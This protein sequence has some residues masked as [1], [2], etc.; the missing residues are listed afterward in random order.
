L[1]SGNII[2]S[3]GSYGL[4]NKALVPFDSSPLETKQEYLD[5]VLK[6]FKSQETDTLRLGE[7]IK[8]SRLTKTK[9][10]RSLEVLIEQ[11]LIVKDNAKNVFY[12]L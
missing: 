11:G 6:I 5:H 12:L 3:Y 9:T 4:G 10:L 2:K 7:V 1:R 8:Q